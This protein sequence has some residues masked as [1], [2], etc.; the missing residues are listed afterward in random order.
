MTENNEARDESPECD[1][2][3]D[4]FFDT[5]AAVDPLGDAER[6]AQGQTNKNYARVG[7]FRPSS[8][9]Y[10]Y[11]PGSVMDMPHFT[12]MPMGLDDWDRI[13]ARR[14]VSYTPSIHAPRLL[15]SVRGVLGQQVKE[16]RALPWQESE[17]S[18]PNEGSDLGVPARVFPQ[19][20]RCTGCDKLAPL[21]E[22]TY[23]N[24]VQKRPD[25][26]EFVHMNCPGRGG[27]GKGRKESPC[28]PARYLLACPEGHL[29]EF[30]YDWFV[31]RGGKCPN[32][33]HPDLRMRENASGRGSG[34]TIECLSCGARRRMDEAQGEGGKKKLPRCRGRHPH[35]DAFDKR[36]NGCDAQPRLMLV[37]ASNLWFPVTQSIVDMPPKEE[38]DIA[39]ARLD[40][41]VSFLGQQ[42]FFLEG[43]NVDVI[44]MLVDANPTSPYSLRGLSA[45]EFRGLVELYRNPARRAESVSEQWD[46][47]D[48]LL[49][50]WRYLQDDPA[51][52]RQ[53]DEASGL[54]L[55]PRDVDDRLVQMGVSRLLSVDSLRKVNALLGFTRIDDFDRVADKSRLVR[56][57][58]NNRPKWI[59][60][61][62]DH[63]EGIFIQLNEG[64]V[65]AWEEK[66][67]TSAL[68]K[69][70]QAAFL[71][72]Y[73][74]HLSETA[75]HVADPLALM[76]APRYWLVHTLAH[77][78]IRRMAVSSGYGI[79]S[80]SERLYAW[81][82][83]EEKHRPAA[84]GFIIMTTA[85][86]S[87]G[88][89]GGLVALSETR[90]MAALFETALRD[91]LRCSSDP[92]CGH[93]I[94]EEP[95]DFLHGASCHCCTMVSET[96][97]ERA[98][99]FLDRRFLVSLP[100]DCEGEPFAD[101]AFFEDIHV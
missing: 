19:W 75:K 67:C 56:L 32:A 76:P 11:G 29:D 26:A 6:L 90:K 84:A 73:R 28:V 37:G 8:F 46:P 49:P 7:T 59:P 92:V 69:K 88:T 96:S 15:S 57:V 2:S 24:T 22:F 81:C 39:Q 68:W 13:Y 42:A 34:A 20:M 65:A 36:G 91:A 18:S 50:E 82:A 33:T 79:P 86:D 95:E 38:A 4:L 98:N 25:R 40:D 9:M 100:G 43:G 30:P 31:H 52:E 71:R 63:G 97:C 83:N 17:S 80:L 99:R 12:V 51:T 78:L 1:A 77:V 72:N 47:V 87:D 66:V 55:S 45:E 23:K 10:T 101:L 93:R 70:H 27:K 60:A 41:L 14:N 74:N 53:K 44:K 16:L 35:L 62:E 54:T 5:Q 21:D 3:N 64:K 61:T 94:P 89:L 48:L 58:R 85:S